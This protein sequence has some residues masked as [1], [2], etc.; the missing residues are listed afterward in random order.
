METILDVFRVFSTRQVVMAVLDIVL[1]WLL[2]YWVLLL[3]RGTRA[4]QVMLGFVALGVA[5]LAS[6][7]LELS[8]VSWLLDN[9]LS[10]VIILAIVVFQSE[11]RTALMRVGRQVRLPWGQ[12]ELSA[13][14][15]EVLR[16]VE[17]LAS[18]SQGALIVFEREATLDELTE[19]GVTLD[20]KVSAQLL[21]AIFRPDP[22][23]P[24]H[25][26]AVVI[27]DWRIARASVL[28]PL[29]AADDLDE[30]YG[31]RH[32]A[33]IGITEETDA[34]SV[35]VSEERGEVSVCFHGNIVSGVE[36]GKLKGVLTNLLR[37]GKPPRL[38]AARQHSG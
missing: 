13:S 17:R 30:R 23:N 15:E 36:L 1:V 32:R 38:A 27:R 28:L 21:M 10:Y 8:T 12:S 33:A 24:I 35:V 7:T 6:R 31:T 26:G 9:V 19:G 11:I 14:L 25:D 3:I 5:L 20:A 2:I 34:V 16:S 22:E 4:A 29:S 18:L 37:R